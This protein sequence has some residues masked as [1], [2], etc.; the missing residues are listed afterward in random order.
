[1][2]LC[3]ASEE[4][5][6]VDSGKLC[7]NRK[8]RDKTKHTTRPPP[9]FRSSTPLYPWKVDSA[10]LTVVCVLAFVCVCVCVCVTT[11]QV[12]LSHPHLFHFP[13]CVLCF[14]ALRGGCAIP[15][16]FAGLLMQYRNTKLSSCRLSCIL[17]CNFVSVSFLLAPRFE[18]RERT[19]RI[20]A[21]CL[22]LYIKHVLQ[23]Q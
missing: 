19:K 9:P 5:A 17:Y 2:H 3:I 21:K 11:M 6:Q 23:L 4:S 14:L 8:C 1:M 20:P 12:Q 7:A 13:S 22:Q 16:P 18:E 15:T 10:Y